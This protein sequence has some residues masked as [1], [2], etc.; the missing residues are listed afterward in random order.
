MTNQ[1]ELSP[2]FSLNYEETEQSRA[3]EHY[4]EPN[5]NEK[6]PQALHVFVIGKH[7]EIVRNEI[8]E[9]GGKL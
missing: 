4:L 3:A 1:Q 6:S 5:T 9:K 8:I 7:L 2:E